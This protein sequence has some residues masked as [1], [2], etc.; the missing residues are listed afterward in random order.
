M[1][2]NSNSGTAYDK[3]PIADNIRSLKF[4]YYTDASGKTLLTN[5]D[6]SAIVNGRDAGAAAA[7]NGNFPAAGTGAIGGDGKYDPDNIGT[8]TNF[9][10]R[11][12]RALIA[13]IRT[14]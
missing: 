7:P 9:A 4:S 2:K 3:A 14:K 13:S 11:S 5:A 10:D 12:Q 1:K 6:G 8:T